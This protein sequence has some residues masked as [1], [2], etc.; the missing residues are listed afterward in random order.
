MKPSQG[1]QINKVY[2]SLVDLSKKKSD[3]I[4]ARNNRIDSLKTE[5]NRISRDYRSLGNNYEMHMKGE[6]AIHS[7]YEKDARTQNF[8]MW[9]ALIF[10]TFI[11]L[12][13]TL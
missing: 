5:F 12:T 9:S 10:C 8:L 7:G 11:A 3:S 13:R 2:D 6:Y 1:V 4:I